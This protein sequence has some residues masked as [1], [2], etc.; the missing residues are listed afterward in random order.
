MDK[1]FFP[2]F[3]QP[4]VQAVVSARRAESGQRVSV[5]PRRLAHAV[6]RVIFDVAQRSARVTWRAA[7]VDIAVIPASRSVVSGLRGFEIEIRKKHKITTVSYL[8]NLNVAM[9]PQSKFFFMI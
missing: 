2:P 7:N 5:A 4:A 8:A 1:G 9:N 6:R 3:L